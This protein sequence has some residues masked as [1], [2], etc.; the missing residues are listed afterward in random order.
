[1]KRTLLAG[2][3]AAT[4]GLGLV[5]PAHAAPTP[6]EQLS[7]G[8]LA[9]EVQESGLVST[10]SGG[11]TFDDHGL[12]VDVLIALLEL[13]AEPETRARMIAALEASVLEYARGFDPADLYAGATG[14]LA[15]VLQLAGR[16]TDDVE[17]E[18][19]IALAESTV[20][21]EG[22]SAGRGLD[23]TSYGG[24][25]SNGVGQAWLVRALSV[26]GSDLADE[27][28]AYL[29]KQQ[30]A[31]GS[32]LVIMDDAGCT[33]GTG[34]VDGTAFALQAWLVARDNGVAGL[35]DE[36]SAAVANLLA[37][38]ATDGSFADEGPNTNTTGLAANA[39][40]KAG[41]SAAAARAAGWVF[42]KQVTNRRAAGSSLTS[43]IGAIAFDQA[44]LDAG[45]RN[46]ITPELRDQWR[47]AT[48]QAVLALPAAD[49]VV[50]APRLAATGSIVDVDVS[51]LGADEEF[52]LVVA[53]SQVFT[54]TADATGAGTAP[55]TLPE[56]EG[57]VTLTVRG[58]D[59]GRTGTATITALAPAEFDVTV[60][61][62]VARPGAE[63]EIGFG[64]STPAD[65][66]GLDLFVVPVE[67]VEDALAD[68]GEEPTGPQLLSSDEVDALDRDGL[69]DAAVETL[70][71]EEGESFTIDAPTEEGEYV[72]F[73]LSQVSDERGGAAVL[74]VVGAGSAGPIAPTGSGSG[75]G[76]DVTGLPNG[77]SPVTPWSL[78]LALAATVLGAALVRFGM[79]RRANA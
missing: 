23:D 52:E 58:L 75:V 57:P 40:Q 28:A 10:V 4:L 25:F 63:I 45:R 12:S 22:D 41:R 60:T 68:S 74:D 19:L 11:F 14:K 31:D 6:D 8:W 34:D 42:D 69:E 35:D 47:R 66:E 62:D 16:S 21:T 56:T 76:A 53:G 20:S 33:A 46:G 39:L 77:G 50:Q 36:I 61:P 55:L 18:D 72:V 79:S 70:D 29:A 54:G 27:T 17:G 59:G 64:D 65:G 7:A 37:V 38:Q 3:V 2:A 43:E 1:M 30:C 51:R 26:A 73:V 24:E 71:V 32:V 9:G 44:A 49:V 48:A 67:A 13:D 78:W 5:A 15:A